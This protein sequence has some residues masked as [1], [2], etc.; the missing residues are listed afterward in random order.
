MNPYELDLWL[1][2]SYYEFDVLKN[3]FNA[4]KIFYK[5]LKVL[6]NNKQIWAAY[7]AFEIKVQNQID[8]R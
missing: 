3:P 7:L 2:A 8:S 6:Q 5:A 4:R 1:M